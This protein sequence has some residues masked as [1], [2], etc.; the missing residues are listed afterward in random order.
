MNF[1]KSTWF[2]LLMLIFFCPLGLF[3]MWKYKPSWNKFLKVTLTAV[4]CFWCLIV[5]VGMFSDGSDAP[6]Q[7]MEVD[8]TTPIVTD[9]KVIETT[10]E[11]RTEPETTTSEVEE[12]TEKISVTTTKKQ[13]VTTT[14][15]TQSSSNTKNQNSTKDT[16]TQNPDAQVTVYCTKSGERYHYE[17]PCGN[18]TYYPI[19]LEEAKNRGLT[20]CEKCVLH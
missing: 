5:T 4:C 3:L 10:S 20:A 15:A 18:G 14:K 8:S 7:S 16:V 13:S 2:I 17:N 6:V 19:T 11:I 1:Y 12:T 9:I